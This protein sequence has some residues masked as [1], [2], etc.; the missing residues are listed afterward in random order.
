[1][2]GAVYV[3]GKKR[4]GHKRSNG[5]EEKGDE[6]GGEKEEGGEEGEEGESTV[7]RRKEK[8]RPVF[9]SV[10][11]EDL[12]KGASQRPGGGLSTTVP[13]ETRNQLSRE[14]L[15]NGKG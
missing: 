10:Y 5:R 12:R 2:T 7:G 4:W 1:M 3:K 15:S 11:W 9:S 14:L 6:R 13:F 8:Q